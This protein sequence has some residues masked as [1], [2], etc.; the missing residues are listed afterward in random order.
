MIAESL[1][2][3]GKYKFVKTVLFCADD[4]I[5]AKA[6]ATEFGN[7]LNQKFTVITFLDLITVMQKSN[8]TIEQRKSTMMLWARYIAYEL[9]E[10]TLFEY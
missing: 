10:M 1:L 7:M 5:N 3:S 8:L 2:Q 4:D 6:T 9:S